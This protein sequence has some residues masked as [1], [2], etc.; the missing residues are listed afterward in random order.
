MI[1]HV[2]FIMCV[3]LPILGSAQNH[4]GLDHPCCGN[5]DLMDLDIQVKRKVSLD[6]FATHVESSGATYGN[7]VNHPLLNGFTY[8]LRV[9]WC[10]DSL[11]KPGL[12]LYKVIIDRSRL[13]NLKDSSRVF[14]IDSRDE[15]LSND[16]LTILLF[17]NDA[18]KVS[19]VSGV[20]P[21]SSF[22]VFLK[23]Y[24]VGDRLL[25]LEQAVNIKYAELGTFKLLSKDQSTFIF[26]NENNDLVKV[27]I[28]LVGNVMFE[29][30]YLLN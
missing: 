14:V 18:G 26:I 30:Y 9:L 17:K 4:K 1:N 22:A 19:Y 27:I 24:D 15:F 25:A 8:D 13:I 21:E 29:K 16:T 2:I 23:L 28:E 12:T 6:N 11:F 20:A 3:V 7:L 10:N 5:P